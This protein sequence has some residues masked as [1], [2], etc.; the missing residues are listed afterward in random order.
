[1]VSLPLRRFHL[2]PTTPSRASTTLPEAVARR[3]SADATMAHSGPD[4]LTA[5][6][7]PPKGE[8]ALARTQRLQREQSAKRVSDAIDRDIDRVRRRALGTT[9]AGVE[10]GDALRHAVKG[11]TVTKLL[12]LGASGAGKST[13]CR[14]LRLS[15]VSCSHFWTDLEH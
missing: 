1:M 5:A 2:N 10:D 12:L 3:F 13:F 14:Q 6:L 8:T 7:V 15:V 4:P 11:A 9:C